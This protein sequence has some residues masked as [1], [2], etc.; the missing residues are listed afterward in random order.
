MAKILDGR[1]IYQKLKNEVISEVAKLRQQKIVPTL[2]VISFAAKSDSQGY[3]RARQKLANELKINLEIINFLKV[4]TERILIQKIKQ[5]N[6]NKKIHGIIIDRPLPGGLAEFK[7]FSELD[8]KKDID[9]CHPLSSGNLMQGYPGFVPNTSA[10]VVEILKHYKIKLEGMDTLVIGRSKNVGLPMFPLLNKENATVTLCHSKTKNL[11]AKAKLAQLIV[12]A[13]GIPNFI[14]KEHINKETILI[15]VGTN[16]L[17]NGTLVGDADPK[18]YTKIKAYSP[19]PGG[20]GPVTN[21]ILF[22][23]L[24]NGIKKAYGK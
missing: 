6:K 18:I 14:K 19:V 7:V 8:P 22:K 13:V 10:A 11:A 3:L 9:G 2:A 24:I 4:P 20:V 15:D 21:I 1:P 12:V 23:N 5:L 17:D 16:Y